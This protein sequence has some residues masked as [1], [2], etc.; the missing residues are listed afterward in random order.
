MTDGDNNNGRSRIVSACNNRFPLNS[1][2]RAVLQSC[3]SVSLG[4]HMSCVF[5][6]STIQTNGRQQVEGECTC[7]PGIWNL[8]RHTMSIRSLPKMSSHTKL[9]IGR[10][11]VHDFWFGRVWK[12]CSYSAV[13]VW[14]QQQLKAICVRFARPIKIAWWLLCPD[15]KTNPPPPHAHANIPVG[16]PH[17]GIN[18]SEIMTDRQAS[19]KWKQLY[20]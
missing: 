15:V 5:C 13:T 8:W 14:N 17:N 12:W 16:K 1:I 11:E 20:G 4:M 7:T 10:A 6:T 9:T 2:M 19:G 3:N 18:C